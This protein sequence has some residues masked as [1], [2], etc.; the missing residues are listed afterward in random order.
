MQV[1]CFVSGLNKSIR[2]NIQA[3]QPTTLSAAIGLA[4]LYEAKY[5]SQCDI[6]QPKEKRAPLD[7]MGQPLRGLRQMSSRKDEARGYASIVMTSSD[8]AIDAK[9]SF[10]LKGVDQMMIK[11][12][13]RKNF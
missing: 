8:Q 10:S 12:K 3:L 1:S 2:A 13:L 9:S 4:R 5:Q 6:V 7:Q 11:K